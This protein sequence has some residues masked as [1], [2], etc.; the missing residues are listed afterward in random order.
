MRGTPEDGRLWLH[1]DDDLAPNR[2]GEWLPRQEESEQRGAL[3]R[4]V[5]RLLGRPLPE[6]DAAS[7]LLAAERVADE[8]EQLELGGW[9]VLHSLPLPD[10]TELG[11]L[12][13]GPGGTYA[14][15]SH[16]Y[17]AARARVRDGDTV[18]GAALP[19]PLV[20]H[21]RRD[22]AQTRHVLSRAVGAE[23]PVT[24]VLVLVGARRVERTEGA[25]DD[26]AVLSD[27]NVRGHF[28]R[29]GGV[30]GP[31]EAAGL[32]ALARDRRTWRPTG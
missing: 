28:L 23:V 15:S 14:V 5:A 4:S 27:G 21:S 2:P 32:H 25:S 9:Y 31:A 18:H 8:L 10:G 1:P 17:P 3:A 22:A 7:A 19:L 16:W 6:R 12:L 24:A 13:V 11:H 30:L 26:V 20:R 29:R